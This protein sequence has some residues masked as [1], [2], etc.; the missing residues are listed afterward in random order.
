MAPLIRCQLARA[1]HRLRCCSRP[2]SARCRSVIAIGPSSASMTSATVIDAR[3]PRQPVAAMRAAMRDQQL[4]AGQQLQDLAGH[5]L[6]HRRGHRDLGRRLLPLGLARQVGHDHDAV[7]GELAE[8]DHRLP[9]RRGNWT[10]TVLIACLNGLPRRCA[11]QA[12]IRRTCG[13]VACP[14]AGATLS[15]VPARSGGREREG[16]G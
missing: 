7:V 15:T 5:R 12:A 3:L 10:V 8:P 9:D 6:R 11:C 1:G 16:Q 4:G 2:A 14:V 13:G